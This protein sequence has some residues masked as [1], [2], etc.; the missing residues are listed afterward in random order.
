M[1]QVHLILSFSLKT[2]NTVRQSQEKNLR[3]LSLGVSE[4]GFLG[5]GDWCLNKGR[6]GSTPVVS[7][8][9]WDVG[10]YVAI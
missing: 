8:L 6:V 2:G 10:G 7:N 4:Y 1:I 5:C 9:K 3:S